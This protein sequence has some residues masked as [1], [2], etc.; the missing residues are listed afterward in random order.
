MAFTLFLLSSGVSRRTVSSVEMTHPDDQHLA[1]SR[2]LASKYMATP[3]RLECSTP[4]SCFT[5]QRF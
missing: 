3:V 1:Q 2:I 5:N 4:H